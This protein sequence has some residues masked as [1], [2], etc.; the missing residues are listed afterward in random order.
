MFYKEHL[1]RVRAG[2]KG[3]KT[4]GSNWMVPLC[5]E[6]RVRPGAGIRLYNIFNSLDLGLVIGNSGLVTPIATH[7]SE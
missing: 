6:W 3:E 4:E 1:E 2:A 7:T 5:A